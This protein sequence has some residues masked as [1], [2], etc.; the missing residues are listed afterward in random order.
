M[1]TFIIG[2]D[3]SNHI[4]LNDKLVSRQHAKLTVS[5]IGQVAIKDLGSSNGT[6]VNGNRIT[7]SILKTGDIVKCGSV[8]LE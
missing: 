6:F 2:R 4:V 5:D 3:A 8:F 7:E 1:Q